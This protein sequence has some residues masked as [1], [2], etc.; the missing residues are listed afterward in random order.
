MSIG[1]LLS[2]ARTAM[3][4]QQVVIQTTGQNIANVGTEGYSR[5]RVELAP[6]D[7][8]AFSW[9]TVGTGVRVADVRRARADLLDVSYRQEASQSGAYALRHEL[10]G[11]IEQVLG[12][13]SE[14]GL[15]AGMDA[16]WS[17]F[18][19]LASSPA[20]SAARSVV[21]QRAGQVATTLNGFAARLDEL[22]GQ[23]TLR[24]TNDVGQMNGLLDQ[25]GGL[26]AQIMKLE[27]GGHQASD[28]RDRR[29]VA[30]DAL[31][32]MAD[33]R[34]LPRAD[35]SVQ[36][37]VGNLTMVDGS[38]VQHLEIDPTPSGA[39]PPRL[40]LRIAGTIGAIQPFGGST[41][42]TL[43][44]LNRDLAGVQG[45]LDAMA[46]TL[47]AT[48]N[49]VHG[50]G[51]LPGDVAGG[52]VFVD[53]R[54]GSYVAADPFAPGSYDAGGQ[55][56]KGIVTA[57]T[58]AVSPALLAAPSGLAV[59]SSA[60]RPTDNDVA[61]RLA[62]L[63]T[64]GTVPGVVDGNGEPVPLAY[65]GHAGAAG[66]SLADFYRELTTTLGVQ[67]SGAESDAEVHGALLEQ[68]DQRR[69]S[70][71]GVNLDEEMTNLMRAQQAY[72][73][74]AKVIAAVDEMMDTLT[75]LKR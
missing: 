12:E 30:V 11:E 45:R 35:G 25:I 71:N 22:R 62:G 17:S 54:Y 49:A 3:S 23:A 67:V 68:I 46:N 59:S 36:L 20:S 34:A 7:P 32:R 55:L 26:N 29:D 8:Q 65:A 33:V 47:A 72:A 9:G 16:L 50:Q 24:L 53:G 57:R 52:A 10:L 75:N 2:V 60:A 64:S 27:T 43:D 14:T 73:A 13:P 1:S 31:S 40:A 41:E 48:V 15:A 4:A 21:L 61:L 28:L 38:A 51:R 56:A 58:I 44:L 70:V 6:G 42:A 5:Q 37:V 74:A 69:T 66:T 19:D 39:V 63:R 18:S